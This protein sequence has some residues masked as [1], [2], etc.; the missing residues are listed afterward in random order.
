M[1]RRRTIWLAVAVVLLLLGGALL[2]ALPELI[3][4]QAVTRL[5]A[6]TGRAV[7]MHLGWVTL[8]RVGCPP[9]QLRPRHADAGELA[10]R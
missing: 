7:S 8:R 4:R 6:M 5:P 3:R 10:D 1:S 2:W 9:R